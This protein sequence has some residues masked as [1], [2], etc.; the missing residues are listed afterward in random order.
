MARQ[1]VFTSAPQGLTPG[2][3]GYCTVAR[4]RD[5]RERLVPLLESSSTFP[6]DWQP[7]PVI[8]SFRMVDVGGTRF[9]VLSRIV[10]A[11]YDYTHRGHY[12]AHHLIL[13]PQEIDRALPPADIFLR[14][15]GWL[16]HWEG[17]PRW[18]TENDWVDLTNLPAA[19]LPALPAITWKELTGDG[20]KAALLLDG[21][22]PGNRVLRCPA[23]Q[24]NR[25]LSLL[26]ESSALLPAVERWRAEFTTCLQSAE[27][28][29]GF[30]WVAVRAD[31]PM[32]ASASRSG[33]VLDLTQPE[34]L[35]PAPTNAAA[36]IAR[37]EA[38]LTPGSVAVAAAPDPSK[39][40]LEF[41]PLILPEQAA[42]GPAKTPLPP[43]KT[44]SG[45]N[46]WILVTVAGLVAGGLAALILLWPQ[47]PPAPPPPAPVNAPTI[48]PTMPPPPTAV[49]AP[50]N[51]PSMAS[52]QAL[53]EIESLAQGGSYF[54]ALAKW[55][56][57]A[58]TSPD[59][60]R[61]RGDLL[62][63]QLLPGARK[64]WLDQVGEIAAQL[65]TARTPRADLAAQLADLQKIATLWPFARPGEMTAAAKSVADKIHFLDQLPGDPVWI[66]DNFKISA[67]GEDY[68]DAT[69]MI[70]IP[71]LSAMLGSAAGKFKVSAVGATSLALPPAAQWFNFSVGSGD[72]E[73]ASFLI[74]NDSTQGK[75]GGRF[76]ELVPD[77]PGVTRLT[78]RLFTPDSD[79]V[80]SYPANAPLRPVSQE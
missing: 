52:E 13:D 62:Q 5:L 37:G 45:A 66:V 19:P 50:A 51:N 9:P 12:L 11:G 55:R 46:R 2:R 34:K 56:D 14:W 10:D 71:E 15:N 69:A 40:N 53:L 75:A 42:A 63:N 38:R 32:D 48:A 8:C 35:P 78:W 43:A 49:A 36:R 68:Q 73:S 17:P 70:A 23:G 21:V 31:S 72:F 76:M 44:K 59:L 6:S 79:F 41:T 22:Q 65:D 33:N 58:V 57:F 1:L 30:R 60:A 61:A 25:M 54:E 39:N 29:A 26:R 64:K 24:E 67:K 47:S 74:L 77:S 16:S 28:G 3:T 27:S 4:H 80:Q 7:P 20:G 18:L